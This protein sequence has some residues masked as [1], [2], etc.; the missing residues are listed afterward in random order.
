VLLDTT[1]PAPLETLGAT[2][3][4]S[5]YCSGARRPT[6]HLLPYARTWRLP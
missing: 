3:R 2:H 6:P 4:R 5:G 1:L